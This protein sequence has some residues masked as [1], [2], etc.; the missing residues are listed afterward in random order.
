MICDERGSTKC[1]GNGEVKGGISDG[2]T[3]AVNGLVN[4]SVITGSDSTVSS[5]RNSSLNG[6]RAL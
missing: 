3:H 6:D 1:G 4:D 2:V 5:Y